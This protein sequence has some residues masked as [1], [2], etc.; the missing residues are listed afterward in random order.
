MTG[1]ATICSQQRTCNG[2]IATDPLKQILWYLI[3]GGWGDSKIKRSGLLVTLL[4]GEKIS[5]HTHKEGSC[6]LLR[7]L[8]KISHEHPYAFYMRLPQ[9]SYCCTYLVVYEEPSLWKDYTC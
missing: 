2:F 3:P 4:R 7:V 6:Y 5:S 9:T 1:Y 8:F